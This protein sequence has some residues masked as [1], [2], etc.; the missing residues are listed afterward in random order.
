MRQ[1]IVTISTIVV[2]IAILASVMVSMATAEQKEKIIDKKYVTP[3]MV[4]KI[5]TD[6]RQKINANITVENGQH[7]NTNSILP[8]QLA[9]TDIWTFSDTNHNEI[10]NPILP[11]DITIMTRNITLKYPSTLGITF[12]SE[13]ETTPYWYDFPPDEGYLVPGYVNIAVKI[14]GVYTLPGVV[15]FKQGPYSGSDGFVDSF[16]TNSFTFRNSY[17]GTGTH[18][19]EVKA[20]GSGELYFKTLTV[21]ANGAGH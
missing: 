13:V 4:E 7:E 16:E 11:E 12:S 20:F 8:G 19:I 3:Q 6:I 5:R 1:K 2:I 18:I 21:F 14:D 10:A 17:V 15:W 9:Y